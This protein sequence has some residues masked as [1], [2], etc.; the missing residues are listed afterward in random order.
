MISLLGKT[1]RELKDM[2]GGALSFYIRRRSSFQTEQAT[3]LIFLMQ[4]M[5]GLVEENQKCLCNVSKENKEEDKAR[6][7]L[8]G[9][10]LCLPERSIGYTQKFISLI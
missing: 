6:N 8:F 1:S 2:G 4:N 5:L 10:L 3:S 9:H 7:G